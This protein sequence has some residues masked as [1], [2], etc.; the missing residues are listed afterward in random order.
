MFPNLG[1]FLRG[2][3]AS[4][5]RAGPSQDSKSSKRR[6]DNRVLQTNKLLADAGGSR[7]PDV[8][9]QAQATRSVR[10]RVDGA[11]R[12]A[13][14]R[15][16]F[17]GYEVR[18][19]AAS[20]GAV[21]AISSGKLSLQ[22]DVS[23]RGIGN[24]QNCYTWNKTPLLSAQVPPQI[25]NAAVHLPTRLTATEYTRMCQVAQKGVVSGQGIPPD[26]AQELA[27][28]LGGVVIEAKLPYKAKSLLC[29]G[30]P[31]VNVHCIFQT[32]LNFAGVAGGGCPVGPGAQ[33][34][35]REF[36][37]RNAEAALASAIRNGS[38]VLVFN[39]GIGSGFFA[40]SHGAEVKQ[41]NVSGLCATVKRTK[42]RGSHLEVVVPDV[43]LS[44]Q[45]KQQM[46][47]EGIGVVAAD[48]GAVAA[49][50]ARQKL[51][52]SETFAADPMTMLGIHGPGLWWQT[53][54]SASDEE[55]A[56][57]LTPSYALGYIPI[58]VC[59][60]GKAPTRIPALSQ[61]MAR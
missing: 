50:C 3:S 29:D 28:A 22:Q 34:S 40:G 35:I 52:V 53:V 23:V 58:D 4:T 26:A 31:D 20:D 46:E 7:L 41:A 32:G 12:E 55:R 17:N 13:I 49:L 8:N 37:A 18:F 25:R 56:A 57:F 36:S 44:S 33:Q 15:F 19:P 38:D 54:G 27:L 39:L 47:A 5:G 14:A 11:A 43:G 1:K 6:G 21:P 59:E 30:E 51:K 2:A 9:V 16:K 42:E 48:K 61:F 45:Q 60:V 10:S 24:V